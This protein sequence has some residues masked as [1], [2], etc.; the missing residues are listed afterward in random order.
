MIDRTFNME[1]N[2]SH[3]V[4]KKN[5][6]CILQRL[7]ISMLLL[8]QDFVVNGLKYNWGTSFKYFCFSCCESE[9][10]FKLDAQE[11]FMRTLCKHWHKP[12]KWLVRLIN[13]DTWVAKMLNSWRLDINASLD[14]IFFGEFA[15][16]NVPFSCV[17]LLALCTW[18]C[19]DWHS[20][21]VG[22]NIFEEWSHPFLVILSAGRVQRTRY[23]VR[24]GFTWW[25]MTINLRCYVF[26]FGV[27]EYANSKTIPFPGCKDMSYVRRPLIL[28]LQSNNEYR[29]CLILILRKI[30]KL[31][32]VI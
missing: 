1:T 17:F 10:K 22:N 31:I 7:L 28:P 15:V 13:S 8:N 16:E 14:G 9:S 21:V 29:Y 6:F 11:S 5:D 27:Q 25:R 19:V 18:L 3:F 32:C 24:G 23:L 26:T 12:A 30:S 2:E 20:V 4:W